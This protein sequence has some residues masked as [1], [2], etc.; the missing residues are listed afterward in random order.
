MKAPIEHLE[1]TTPMSASEGTLYTLII[2][3]LLGVGYGIGY[4]RS[5]FNT[6]KREKAETAEVV[7]AAKEQKH[8]DK[9]RDRRSNQ[10][11]TTK[12]N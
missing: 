3:A 12:T 4:A 10:T 5:S 11:Q 9:M 6:Y 7:K 8:F 1:S 2:G